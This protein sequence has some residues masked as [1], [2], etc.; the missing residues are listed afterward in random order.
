MCQMDVGIINFIVSN[1]EKE[2]LF[3]VTRISH[4]S[5]GLAIQVY[6]LCEYQISQNIKSK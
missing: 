5:N 4:L 6:Y 1:K 3:Y 2:H